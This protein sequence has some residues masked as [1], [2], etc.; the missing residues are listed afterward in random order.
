[1]LSPLD[2]GNLNVVRTKTRKY[3]YSFPL[4]TVIMFLNFVFVSPARSGIMLIYEVICDVTISL[5]F[6]G[7]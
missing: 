6:Y 3:G 4:K 7:I 2:I 5:R 1:M